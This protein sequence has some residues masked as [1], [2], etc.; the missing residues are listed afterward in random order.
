MTVLTAILSEMTPI[1]SVVATIVA[2]MAFLRTIYQ[3][4]PTVEF[5][6]EPDKASGEL[7]YKLS[8]SNPTRRLLVLDHILVRSPDKAMYFS[9]PAESLRDTLELALEE[10]SQADRRRKLVY[11]AVPAEQTRYLELSFGGNE[12]NEDFDVD[13]RLVWSKGLPFLEKWFMRGKIKLDSAQVKSRRLA[14]VGVG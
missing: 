2:V 6:V 5:L 1:L 9:R 11:L 10:D 14:A 4:V 7:C 13:F 3:K 12:N 8:V